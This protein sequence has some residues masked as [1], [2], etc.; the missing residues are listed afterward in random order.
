MPA[1]SPPATASNRSKPA[2]RMMVVAAK[3]ISVVRTRGKEINRRQ[4]VYTG[5]AQPEV[6]MNGLSAMK[7][8]ASTSSS[9]LAVSSAMTFL[10]GK[11]VPALMPVPPLSMRVPALLTD[12]SGSGGV[13]FPRRLIDHRAGEVA[14]ACEAALRAPLLQPIENGDQ[15]G[16]IAEDQIA[17]HHRACAGE[18]VLDHIFY[19]DNAPAADDRDLHGLGALIHHPHND[20]LD[21]RA[22]EAAE[23][24]ADRG[25]ESIGI[26][27]EPENSVRHNERIGTGG[28]R[29][30]A[31][32]DHVP[33]IGRELA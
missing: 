6:K 18:H 12:G 5:L 16:R 26:D 4:S 9:I 21:A 25:A 8:T 28:F 22:R 19:L 24:V 23:L 11:T 2:S 27:L 31:D 29:R 20:W 33:G 1:V 14:H 32:R 3:S 10:S 13:G 7:R 30:L 17:D 15:A